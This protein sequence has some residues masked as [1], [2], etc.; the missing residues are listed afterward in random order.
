MG[1]FK[2]Q[3]G[4]IS[5]FINNTENPKAPRYKGKGLDQNGNEVVL[6]VWENTT[7]NG[8]TFLSIIIQDKK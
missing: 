2:Q 7:N 5:V 1:E 4:K 6:S 3:N 8:E